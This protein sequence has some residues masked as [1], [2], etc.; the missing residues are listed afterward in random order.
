MKRKKTGF[1]KEEM[2]QLCKE[3]AYWDSRKGEKDLWKNLEKEGWINAPEAAID[4]TR[5][6]RR[7]K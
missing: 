7:R 3:A 1:T 6:I 2:K 4:P 5:V